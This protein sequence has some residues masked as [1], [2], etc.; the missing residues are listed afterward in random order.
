MLLAIDVGNTNTVIGLF[1]EGELLRSWRLTTIAG[2]TADEYGIL[3]RN[4]FDPAGYE[5]GQ[6]A[7]AIISW[8]FAT[9]AGASAPCQLYP[10]SGMP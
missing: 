10:T 5:A 7:H 4:L 3:F 2:Q 6:V 9:S 8:Y 1:R